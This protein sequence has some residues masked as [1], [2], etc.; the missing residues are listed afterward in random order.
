VSG[1]TGSGHGLNCETDVMGHLFEFRAEG[2]RGTIRGR[3]DKALPAAELAED[4]RRLVNV[5]A[6]AQL[7]VKRVL[8]KG[9]IVRES[10]TLLRIGAAGESTAHIPYAAG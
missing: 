8:Q 7:Q 1:S 3:V 5:P 2:A 10:F 9:Q 4:N 6:R